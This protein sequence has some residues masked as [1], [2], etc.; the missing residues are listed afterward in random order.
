METTTQQ[1]SLLEELCAQIL[2]HILALF[3]MVGGPSKVKVIG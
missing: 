2:L 3:I 1:N